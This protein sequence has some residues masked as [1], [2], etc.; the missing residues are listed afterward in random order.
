[1][2]SKK[3]IDANKHK[4]ISEFY[5]YNTSSLDKEYNKELILVEKLGFNSIND[6]IY[7][8]FT[9]ANKYNHYYDLHL[10][11]PY[12]NLFSKIVKKLYAN[13]KKEFIVELK[14]LLETLDEKNS[15]S[16]N[17]CEYDFFPSSYLHAKRIILE[18]EFINDFFKKNDLNDIFISNKI[19][20]V[21]LIN[22]IDFFY[23]KI[24]DLS[25]GNFYFYKG[26]YTNT[27]IGSINEIETNLWGIIFKSLKKN[28]IKIAIEALI[29]HYKNFNNINNSID[30]LILYFCYRIS[31]S[32]YPIYNINK[33]HSTFFLYKENIQFTD[34]I[35][36]NCNII[37]VPFGTTNYNS[38]SVEEYLLNYKNDK[39]ISDYIN[40]EIRKK[41]EI[42]F[43]CNNEKEKLLSKLKKINDK[44]NTTNN[45]INIQRERKKRFEEL[46]KLT[47]MTSL[48]R[49]KHIIK[50]NKALMFYPNIFFNDLEQVIKNLNKNE[51]KI[52][53]DK[54]KY[55]TKKSYL[56][57]YISL[58]Q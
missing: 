23:N 58:F 54:F 33:N 20:L 36:K 25:T 50:S 11:S 21:E 19:K 43:T 6:F 47:G 44:I 29:T 24:S 26:E 39:K 15:E 3:L 56:K 28:N 17:F 48:D 22:E 30:R 49:I 35:L 34:W 2:N 14:K 10:P 7:W 38:N 53:R 52:L 5:G 12:P 1:M 51:L 8:I 31:G 4:I 55:I 45:K 41:D 37:N 9:Q 57:K 42:I 16:W 27:S 32:Y 13:Y 46:N 40:S 18:N